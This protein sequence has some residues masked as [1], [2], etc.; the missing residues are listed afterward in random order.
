MT[1]RKG[2]LIFG[3]A[4]GLALILG[5]LAGAVI[6][7]QPDS[8][9]WHQALSGALA[10][11]CGM[12]LGQY[13]ADEQ[14]GKASRASAAWNGVSGCAAAAIPGLPFLVAGRLPATVASLCIIAALG[15]VI[16]WLRPEKGLLA[17][18]RTYGLLLAVGVLSGLSGLA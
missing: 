7:R 5:L 3:M 1:V 16:C 6:S 12:S 15:A 8:A 17:V 10:E 4:D 13:W 2:A 11:L 14:A 9:V 18:I